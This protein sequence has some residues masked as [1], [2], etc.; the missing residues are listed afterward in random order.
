MNP[1]KSDR[2]RGQEECANF[3]L[4]LT[5]LT[6]KWAKAKTATEDIIIRQ[7]TGACFL[8]GQTKAFTEIVILMDSMFGW[9]D[10]S[11]YGG[12][13]HV[14]E[15]VSESEKT[16]L[17]LTVQTCRTEWSSMSRYTQ[18]YTTH[19]DYFHSCR[20]VPAM[21]YVTS[22]QTAC[23]RTIG[24]FMTLFSI[25]AAPRPASQHEETEMED[26]SLSFRFIE[27]IAFQ[28]PPL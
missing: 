11:V 20:L 23:F 13:C 16:I 5:N 1:F 6:R 2:G 27:C 7:Q 25:L 4:K 24:R 14:S 18:F 17:S 22:C 10:T 8:C 28:S 26:V 15:R 3:D 12:V 19:N 21:E 9:E